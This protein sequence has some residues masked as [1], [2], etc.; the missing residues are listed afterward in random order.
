MVLDVALTVLGRPTY[1]LNRI[2]RD[3][4]NDGDWIRLSN[5]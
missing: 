1:L 5:A 4:T 3:E 2:F